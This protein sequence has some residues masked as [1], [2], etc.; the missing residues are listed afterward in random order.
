MLSYDG[1]SNRGLW[2]LVVTSRDKRVERCKVR[3]GKEL[4]RW[5]GIGTSQLDIGQ[6]GRGHLTISDGVHD[7]DTVV[8]VKSGSFTIFRKSFRNLPEVSAPKN[9]RLYSGSRAPYVQLNPI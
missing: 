4:V 3:F 1:T 6:G 8:T 2:K 9:D 7:P 5:D